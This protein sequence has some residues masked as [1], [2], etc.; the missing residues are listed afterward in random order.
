M[1]QLQATRR[2][3]AGQA[4]PAPP[5]RG[6]SRGLVLLLATACGTAAANLYYAQPLLHT[7]ATTFGVSNGTAGLLI[8]ISQLGYVVGLAL[9]VPLGD[10]RERRGL[11]SATML[12]TAAALVLSAVAP[13]F[14]VL[15]AAL[16]VV[17]VTSVVAQIV[18]PMS[19]SLAAEHE[20]GSVVGTVMSGLL[21]GILLARTVSGLIAAAFGWR[22]VY[23]FAAAAMVI[24]AA[25][26]RRALPRVPPTTDLSYGDL[27][28]SVVALVREEPVL[29]QRMMVGALTFGC[30]ST[31]WTSLAFLLSGAPYHYGNGVIGLFGLVGVVGAL[32]ASGAGRLAD[33]GHNAR[34]TTATLL[35]MFASWGVLALGKTSVVALIAGIALL[36]LGVQG[37]HISNQSAIYALRPEARSRLTTAYMMAYFLG[38]AALSAVSSALYGADGWGGICVLGAVTALLALVGWIVTEAAAR[39]R[40]APARAVV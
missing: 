26:L 16:A 12:V 6:I 32:A 3:D 22:V 19:S 17:G 25:T 31:L 14:A 24:L 35:I 40:A 29:R 7:L 27:L 18:V 4:D 2:P 34:V 30:F 36:D 9:L 20:R 23:W 39:R 28:R 21:I 13:S 38:G 15:G 10:L 33:R 1:P 37:A 5:T 8:T 11:I